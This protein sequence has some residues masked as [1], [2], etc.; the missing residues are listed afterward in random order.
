MP[1]DTENNTSDQ[2]THTYHYF[3]YSIVFS[4]MRNVEANMIEMT[5]RGIPIIFKICWYFVTPI[6]L[7]VSCTIFFL[8]EI[9]EVIKHSSCM[10]INL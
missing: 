10:K 5:G 9:L 2:L 8:L 4:G 6:L 7:A 1:S 3:C